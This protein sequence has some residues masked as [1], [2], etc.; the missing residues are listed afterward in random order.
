MC[1]KKKDKSKSDQILP[2]QDRIRIMLDW[3]KNWLCV[4]NCLERE[5]ALTCA[6]GASSSSTPSAVQRAEE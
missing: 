5:Q 6:L 1:K 3:D 2:E 4:L